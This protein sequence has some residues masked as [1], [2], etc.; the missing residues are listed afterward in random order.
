[1]LLQ[2]TGLENE[3]MVARG[4]ASQ[5]FWCCH[6]QSAVYK[7]SNQQGHAVQRV[8]LCLVSCADWVAWGF[9]GE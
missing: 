2:L 3:L 6:V 8:Q 7:M 5:G 1:M 9:G 4:M